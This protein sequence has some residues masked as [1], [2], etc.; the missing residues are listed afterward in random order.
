MPIVIKKATRC[1][2]YTLNTNK[3]NM[4]AISL[5]NKKSKLKKYECILNE[6][7]IFKVW[8]NSCVSKTMN[9]LNKRNIKIC[10]VIYNSN[11]HK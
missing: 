8:S 3:W 9:K 1:G 2:V 11:T 10:K 4:N 5:I 7:L 6:K